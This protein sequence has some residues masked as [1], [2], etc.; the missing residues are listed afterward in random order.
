MAVALGRG[1]AGPDPD[2][3][4]AT[5]SGQHPVGAE[6]RQH[7]VAHLL[8]LGRA[9]GEERGRKEPLGQVV[10]APVA[11][12]PGER[13]DAGLRQRLEDRPD[14][15]GRAPVPVDRRAWLDVGR[16]QRSLA[17]D[18]VEE[19]LDEVG[20]L[21]ERLLAVTRV[22]S[23]PADPIPRQLA[24]RQQREALV[25]RLEQPALLVQQ[26]IGPRPLIARDPG[27]EH[28]IVVAPGHVERVELERAQLLDHH[29][30]GRRCGRQ[31]ARWREEVAADEEPA[32]GRAV[33]RDGRMGWHPPMVP[34][35]AVGRC[36]MVR[37]VQMIWRVRNIR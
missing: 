19:L 18:P 6:P 31:G 2:L 25:V 12:A 10:D 3:L 21:V 5:A 4:L 33:D 14:L 13:Q 9:L 11:L 26:R 37:Q 8:V 1:P 27:G 15:V 35:R 32:R 29:L 34:K 28:E 30:H 22:E 20:V 23:V 7:L 16:R 24:G 17:P 36:A